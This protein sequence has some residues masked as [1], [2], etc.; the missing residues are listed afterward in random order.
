MIQNLTGQM[1][2]HRVAPFL[3]QLVAYGLA[4]RAEALSALLQG[5]SSARISLSG[6]Q[7]RLIHPLNVAGTIASPTRNRA[8]GVARE[9]IKPLLIAGA[10][11]PTLVAVATRAAGQALCPVEIEHLITE[12]VAQHLRTQRLKNVDN[13]RGEGPRIQFKKPAA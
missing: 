9:A 10:P 13:P 2:S 8:A 11:K 6:R 4:G 12:A 7:A 5:T 3:A 1:A